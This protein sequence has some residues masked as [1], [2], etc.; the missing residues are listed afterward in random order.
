[1]TYKKEPE[2]LVPDAI[3]DSLSVYLVNGICQVMPPSI[4][5][6]KLRD[7]DETGLFQI[8]CHSPRMRS[9]SLG[10]CNHSMGAIFA[11]VEGEARVSM[12]WECPKCRTA[13]AITVTLSNGKCFLE[14]SK[15]VNLNRGVQPFV[16][17][18]LDGEKNMWIR[19]H[20]KKS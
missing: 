13:Y 5:K 19:V 16:D 10:M 3:E 18:N 7:K 6:S 4:Q 15:V 1:M 12:L 20:E 11:N 9:N 8:W 17:V 2:Y 14:N